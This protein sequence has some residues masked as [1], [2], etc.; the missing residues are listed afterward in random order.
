MKKKDEQ[1]TLIFSRIEIQWLHRQLMNGRLMAEGAMKQ[2]TGPLSEDKTAKLNEIK[3]QYDEIARLEQAVL[4]RIQLGDQERLK[5]VNLKSDLEEAMELNPEASL[6]I[7]RRLDSLPKEETYNITFDRETAKFTLALVEK[8]LTKFK[9]HTIPNY[10]KKDASDFKD[11]VQNKTY[12]VNKAHKAKTVL[13]A[14]KSKIE[15][16]L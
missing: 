3:V 2:F 1:F 6:E 7:R 8:D 12:W 5:L 11:P 16:E 9:T 13:D 4:D 10:E 15:V 14:L